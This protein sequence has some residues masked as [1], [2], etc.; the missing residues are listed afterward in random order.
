MARDGIV[1]SEVPA[2]SWTGRDDRSDDPGLLHLSFEGLGRDGVAGRRLVTIGIESRVH[3]HDAEPV[4]QLQHRLR[5]YTS[6]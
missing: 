4:L 2:R 3:I 1:R 5:L 6:R